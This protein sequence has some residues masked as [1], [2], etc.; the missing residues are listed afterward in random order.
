VD[1][2]PT[3]NRGKYS[4]ICY[5]PEKDPVQDALEKGKKT[6]YVKLTLLN[7]GNELKVAA[8]ASG[9]PEQFVLHVHSAI[10]A[11]KQKGLDTNFAEAE[12]TVIK[13]ELEAESAKM[14]YVKVCN[15]E[16][17]R[18]KAIS[19]KTISQRSPTLTQRP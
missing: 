16:K 14:E 2:V 10:H 19:Q 1:R 12:Q 17:K 13:A 18:I 15:S 11:C 4:P 9:T 5:I 8:W 6:T 3:L 7:T